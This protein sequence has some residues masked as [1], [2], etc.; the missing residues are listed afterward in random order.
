MRSFQ[1]RIATAERRV[2]LGEERDTIQ[3]TR[4]TDCWCLGVG[5]KV[6]VTIP[7]TDIGVYMETC[8]CAEGEEQRL[9]R[10]TE[11]PLARKRAAELR[12]LGIWDRAAIPLAFKEFRLGTWP[13]ALAYPKLMDLLVPLPHKSLMF[14]GSYG[15]GKTGLAIGYAYECLRTL[16]IYSIRFIEAPQML[17]ELRDT[18]NHSSHTETPTEQQVVDKYARCGLLIFDDLGAEQVRNTGWVE[19]RLYQIIGARHDE[20]RPTVFTSNLSLAQLEARIGERVT[21]RI[22]EMVGRAG[23]VSLEGCPNLRE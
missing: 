22:G 23:I 11:Y 13:S 4:P 3:A 15:T 19:D 9:L 12:R 10:E 20:L 7:D 21:W 16:D 6:R 18:Y 14:F 2:A 17:A 5:G 8:G 1:A